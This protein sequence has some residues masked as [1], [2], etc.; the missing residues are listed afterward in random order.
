[1]DTVPVYRVTCTVRNFILLF[2][3]SHSFP[4]LS[5][6]CLPLPSLR[7]IS[8]ACALTMVGLRHRFTFITPVSIQLFS[9]CSFIV[10]VN[11]SMSDHNTLSSVYLNSYSSCPFTFICVSSIAILYLSNRVMFSVMETEKVRR[12]QDAPLTCK[13]DDFG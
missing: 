6:S 9:L 8:C 10:L 3:A 7:V 1:M 12:R 11:L 5:C 13:I 2:D 4:Y